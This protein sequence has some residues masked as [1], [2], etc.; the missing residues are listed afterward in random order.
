MVATPSPPV[1]QTPRQVQAPNLGDRKLRWDA[2]RRWRLLAA[3]AISVWTFAFRFFDPALDE[4]HF[5]MMSQG[6]QVA[7]YGELPIRDFD[8]PGIFLQIFTSAALQ[9]LFGH[10]FLAQVLFDVLILS[11][12]AGLTCWLAGR[13]ARSIPL[14]LT[15]TLLTVAMY[16]R[17]K[18]HQVVFLPVLGLFACW[19]YADRRSLPRLVILGI[20]TALAFLLRHDLGVYVGVTVAATLLA[21][22]WSEGFGILLRRGGVYAVSAALPLLPFLLFLQANGGVIQYFRAASDYIRSEANRQRA[23][24]LPAFNVLPDAPLLAIEP[25]PAG[26]VKVRWSERISRD[27]QAELERQY[28]LA[29][30]SLDRG[31]SRLTTW[32]YDL[33]DGSESNL[34]SLVRDRRVEDTSGIDRARYALTRESEPFF[35]EWLRAIPLFWIRIAPG[36]VHGGNGLRWLYYLFAAVPLLVVSMVLLAFLRRRQVLET[37]HLLTTAALALAI[38]PS[39]RMPLDERL[40][41]AAAPIAI[42]GAWL[43]ARWLGFRSISIPRPSWQQTLVEQ[44]HRAKRGWPRLAAAVLRVG[45]ALLL[46]GLTWASITSIPETATRLNEA[47]T[48]PN[49][50]ALVQRGMQ[51]IANLRK[52]PAETRAG[53]SDDLDRFSDYLRACTSPDQRVLATW[54]APPLYFASERGLAGRHLFWFRGYASSEEEQRRTIEKMRRESVPII[55]D[56]LNRPDTTRAFPL[57]QAYIDEHYQIGWESRA[58]AGNGVAYRV[59]VDRRI[60]PRGTFEPGGYPC[61]FI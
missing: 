9:S 50:P 42:L 41:D 31:D 37:P 4:D 24:T 53:V 35:A 21:V 27:D 10:S 60:T 13:A 23:F 11:I 16:P 20:I 18:Q 17:L 7:A 38:L 22:H 39:I 1:V 44:E 46:L 12:A 26:Q 47:R 48:V 28:R 30:P 45:A 15:V 34:R 6:R 19:A 32:K 29:N 25:P 40:A 14:G 55:I 58:Q 8:D 5:R 59:L 43:L 57:V 2:Q 61:H 54:F 33:L 49:P 3:L 51:I 56:R 36:L 52:P